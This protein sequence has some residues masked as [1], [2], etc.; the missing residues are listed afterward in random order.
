M[1]RM[2]CRLIRHQIKLK[3]GI[4][5]QPPCGSSAAAASKAPKKN[6][7][8]KLM[9]LPSLADCRSIKGVL[10]QTFWEFAVRAEYEFVLGQRAEPQI[11]Y[12]QS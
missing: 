4:C 12:H 9:L 3:T 6:S 1:E 11:Q 7:N 2:D 8:A 5:I 10:S